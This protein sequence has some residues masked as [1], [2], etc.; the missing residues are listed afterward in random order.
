MYHDI[1]WL[2]WVVGWFVWVGF[3]VELIHFAKEGRNR[4]IA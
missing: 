2:G 4:S 1:L 3:R